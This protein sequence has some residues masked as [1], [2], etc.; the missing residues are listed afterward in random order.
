M[1]VLAA[2]GL[3]QC[4]SRF[5]G[6]FISAGGG[7]G[8]AANG[9]DIFGNQGVPGADIG[10]A[11][12]PA[13]DV[14]WR[15]FRDLHRNVPVPGCFWLW[16]TLPMSVLAAGFLCIFIIQHDCGHGSFFRSRQ[17]NELIGRLC[18]LMTLAPYASLA[19]AARQHHSS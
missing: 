12:R 7:F 1:S 15:V 17:A 2:A 8:S 10:E 6:G 9:P 4:V 3:W 5:V 13:R 18:S 19:P 14:V 11:A 16:I